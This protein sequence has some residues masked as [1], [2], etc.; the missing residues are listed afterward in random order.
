MNF[1]AQN[2]TSNFSLQGQGTRQMLLEQQLKIQQL[3]QLQLLQQQIFQQQMELINGGQVPGQANAST[4]QRILPHGLPTPASSTELRA[5]PSTEFVSPMLLQHP[6]TS[7]SMN[8]VSHLPPPPTSP[9]FSQ[10]NSH[11]HLSNSA[12]ANIAFHMSPLQ[13]DMDFDVSPLTSP[14]LEAY[15]QQ[16]ASSS[17]S[18]KRTASPSDDESHTGPS[19][20]RRSSVVE[21]ASSGRSSRSSKS[22]S[23]TPAMRPVSSRKS[24]SEVTGDTPSPVD[25]SMPPPAQP[26]SAVGA[27]IVFDSGVSTRGTEEQLTPV[28]PASI[29]NLGR[30]GINSSLVPPTKPKAGEGKAKTNLKCKSSEEGRASKKIPAASP[31]LKPILPA[32]GNASVHHP[33]QPTL[34]VKKASHKDAEQKRRD[35]LKTSFDD[36]RLLLPPIP[37]PS[38]ET[39]SG[40]PVLPG[41]MPPRGPPRPGGGPNVNVSKLQLLRCGNDFIRTLKGRVDRRNT[42]IHSLRQEIRRLRSVIG[43]RDV[44]SKDIDLDRD[45]D[46]VERDKATYNPN[47]GITD[48]DE[49]HEDILYEGG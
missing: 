32:E 31:S 10:H 4:D 46:L 8:T 42:E 19:R 34:F 1:S 35:S 23:C 39:Y 37:L 11:H 29:M 16:H 41:A 25:L 14:W 28:T 18:N 27:N 48:I 2:S 38:D 17:S 33:A 5:Q 9:H 40:E 7:Y 12:P 43:D 45:L 44:L 6:T 24:T 49:A 13:G 20:K 15:P 3:Q 36:L 47:S 21:S 26:A 30:L 22:G